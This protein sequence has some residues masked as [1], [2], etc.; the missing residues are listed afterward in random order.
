MAILHIDLAVDYP[1]EEFRALRSFHER[2]NHLN[3]CTLMQ[4][5]RASISAGLRISSSKG[6][7]VEV[8][9]PAEAEVAEFLMRFRFFYLKKEPTHFPRILGIIRRHAKGDSV[10]ELVS[11][12]GGQWRNSLFKNAATLRLNGKKIGT[13]Y[14]L[15]L[16]FNAHYF[17]GDQDKSV[18]LDRLNSI[19]SED[20]SKYLLL[21]SVYNAVDVLQ[22]FHSGMAGLF[23]APS[24]SSDSSDE[25][26]GPI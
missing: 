22:R 16:W 4:A 2:M 11:V 15:D 3:T 10:H 21:D 19:L 24:S 7:G 8:K 13:E 6:V 18:E 17:H 12:L 1:E 9:L 23:L 20:L 26:T 5:G 14:V 25:A